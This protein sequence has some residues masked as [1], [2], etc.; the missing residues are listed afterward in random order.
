METALFKRHSGVI[1]GLAV[2]VVFI[3]N[4]IKIPN[5]I[6]FL[7]TGV[8]AGPKGLHLVGSTHQVELLAELGVV[9]LLFTIG[10][11]FSFKELARMKKAM[12]LAGSVQTAGT[13]GII[14]G[15]AL[16]GG[17]KPGP[18]AFLGFMAALS[19]TAIV[20]KVM[21]A[22]STVDSAQGRAS[23]AILIFQD[24]AVVAMLLC[25][26]LLAGSNNGRRRP[27]RPGAFRQGRFRGGRFGRRG[28]MGGGAAFGRHGQ[29]AQPGAFRGE[30]G[31]GS[32]GRGLAHLLGRAVSGPGG[33][34]GRAFGGRKPVRG[35]DGCQR[36]AHARSVH[37][38]VLCFR[39]HA[40]RPGIRVGQP[41]RG[42]A[43]GA[44]P[45]WR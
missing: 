10:L 5:I 17:S 35:A 40:F 6:A 43:F 41:R 16:W 29:K 3:C 19:S 24:V 22:R 18:A 45:F 30:C 25:A 14:M 9:L 27:L 32:S 13:I 33:V 8:L 36:F 31:P 20:L 12:L 21:E 1:A 39:G 37:Q 34:F 26:P 15:L 28:Q 44:G 4:R 11:E 7:L 42:G 2:A 23:L 38:P